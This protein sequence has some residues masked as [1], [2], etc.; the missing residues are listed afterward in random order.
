MVIAS[1]SSDSSDG[2]ES[3]CGDTYITVNGYF[4]DRAQGSRTSMLIDLADAVI[5]CSQQ[6]Q[7]EKRTRTTFCVFSHQASGLYIFE[8]F[9]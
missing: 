5:D 2:A 8:V 6:T 4:G 3:Q 9:P 1:I 7:R